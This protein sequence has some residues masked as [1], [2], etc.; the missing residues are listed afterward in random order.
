M[1]R[2]KQNIVRD[3]SLTQIRTGER[4]LQL[5]NRLKKQ[6]PLQAPGQLGLPV[7]RP[8]PKAP[9]MIS[10]KMRRRGIHRGR[11]THYGRWGDYLPVPIPTRYDLM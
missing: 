3:N 10:G 11:G 2:I 7:P 9:T 4:N 6:N 8:I 5:I 1:S